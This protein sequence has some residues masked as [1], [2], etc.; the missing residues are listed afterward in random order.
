MKVISF[1]PE[2]QQFFIAVSFDEFEIL[3]KSYEFSN[4]TSSLER[5]KECNK[6]DN[7]AEMIKQTFGISEM[8]DLC[9]M[10]DRNLTK[11]TIM[12]HHYPFH[13]LWNGYSPWRMVDIVELKSLDELKTLNMTYE[14]KEYSEE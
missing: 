2:G 14:G 8:P 9:F 10:T 5:C 13:Q 7:Y 4:G 11:M 3:K 1:N 6:D 12:Q